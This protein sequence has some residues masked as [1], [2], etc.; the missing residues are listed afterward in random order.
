M[1]GGT[2]R[3]YTPCYG[4]AI[5]R[6]VL[7]TLMVLFVGACAGMNAPTAKDRR[8]QVDGTAFEF[9]SNGSAL[10]EAH[11]AW[12]VRVR[13]DA[14]WIAQFKAGKSREFGTFQ[15]SGDESR[16][17]WALIEEA[18]IHKR[19]EGQELGAEVPAYSFTVLRP[20]KL[21]H[22]TNVT[23]QDAARDAA[24]DELVTY[25]QKLVRKYTGKKAVI[26]PPDQ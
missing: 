11:G 26:W 25:L 24:L 5:R 2:A 4:R 13:G 14:M 12:T 15:L 18:R 10:T 6:L 22:T 3:Q 19:A 1:I 23:S 7:S 17:L 21:S 20:K 9:S 16:R 8:G